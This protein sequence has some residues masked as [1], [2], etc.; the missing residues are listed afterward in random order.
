M[1]VSV[2]NKAFTYKETQTKQYHKRSSMR[3]DIVASKTDRQTPQLPTCVLGSKKRGQAS[4]AVSKASKRAK[5][6]PVT[7]LN[8][9]S[10]AANQPLTTSFEIS[11]AIPLVYTGELYFLTLKYFW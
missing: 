11:S 5:Q 2:G 6:I 1:K 8:L 9:C 7:V 4:N 10:L 3:C